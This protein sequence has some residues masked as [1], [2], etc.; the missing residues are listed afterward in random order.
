MRNFIF[1]FEQEQALK[2][3]LN[4]KDLLLLDYMYKFFNS[5]QIKRQRKD[6]KFYCRLTYNKVLSDL[7]IFHI[8]ERQLR[9]MI[10]KLEAKGILERLSELKNQ[11]HLYVNWGLL[12]GSQFPNNQNQSETGFSD[13][14]NSVPT[15]DI[16]NNNKI[17]I[18]IENARVKELDLELFNR[19]LHELLKQQ[20]SSISY[21][22]FLC[23]YK[24]IETHEDGITFAVKWKEHLEKH[25]MDKFT[26][27]VKQTL[28]YFI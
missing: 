8:K 23:K 10:I 22:L 21:S 27:T 12:F 4:L 1:E 20:F 11:M 28:K 7:P 15:I 24:A 26:Q 25:F 9:N 6:E 2:L 17:K 16:E 13:V 5:D 3:N 14:G 19:K 18:T